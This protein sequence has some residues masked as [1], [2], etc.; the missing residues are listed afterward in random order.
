MLEG[1]DVSKLSI[2]TLGSHSA[3]NIL[4]GA[5]DESFRTV[6]V[7]KHGDELVYE[8]FRVADVMISVESFEELAND[9][10]Q[11]RLL[12]LNTILVPHGSFNAYIPT[13]KLLKLR[14]PMFGNKQLLVWETNRELQERW[15]RRAGLRLPKVFKSPDEIDCLVIVKFPGAR[16]G[17]GYFLT[18]S[19]EDFW[20]KAESFLKTGVL[21]EEDLRD[22][23]IQEYVVGVNVY[24][25]Y[26]RSL[27]HEETELLAIDRRYEANVDALWKIPAS[28]Q[29]QLDLSPTYTVVGNI[30]L[31]LRESLLAEILRMGDAVVEASEKIAM[32]GIIGA[33]CLETV[34]TENLEIYTFEI[35]ARIVAGTNVGIGT[36]PYAYLRHGENMFMGRR[37]A[38]EIKEAAEQGRL[39]EVLT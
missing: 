35:S 14:V 24:P 13:E 32:P 33:F 36:S 27:L 25:S 31:M 39:E 19:P 22:V 26:F 38:L 12:E 23:H 6:V 18:S 17:R 34:I 5:K 8:R 20:K 2:G 30:P 11:E 4:K 15:L 7:C 9:E 28:E 16:G 21:R 3:L 10:I 37:I 1:Y 29:L